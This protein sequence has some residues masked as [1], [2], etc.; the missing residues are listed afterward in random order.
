M[1]QRIN[2]DKLGACASAIC[3]V[4]CLLTGIALGLLSV[5]GLGFFGSLWSDI[6]FMSVAV[7]IGSFAV[8]HGIRS[9]HS[10][11]PASVFVAGLVFIVFGHFVFRHTHEPGVEEPV[12]MH[13]ASVTFSVL[14]G[15]SL[16]TFHVLNLRLR[17]QGGCGCE[18]CAVVAEHDLQAQKT[19]AS[20]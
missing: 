3:A 2:L 16:V 11:V 4:H 8:I 17:K 6:A 5:A 1:P 15:L 13:A 9:H 20:V 12:F 18:S 19:P 10:Y 14:G 7:F